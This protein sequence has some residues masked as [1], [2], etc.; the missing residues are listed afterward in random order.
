MVRL[1]R[2]LQK[3]NWFFQ[4]NASRI[5]FIIQKKLD[6]T[7]DS[8]GHWQNRGKKKGR[9]YWFWNFHKGFQMFSNVFFLIEK[10][11]SCSWFKVSIFSGFTWYIYTIQL[12]LNQI[13]INEKYIVYFE[14][15]L[16]QYFK[17]K[18]LYFNWLKKNPVSIQNL[19]SSLAKIKTTS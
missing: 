10:L 5:D 4:Q 11:D 16:I 3:K 15:F 14:R 18:D 2:M 13:S 17:C 8:Y 1:D 19:D 6:F 9:E 7:V 12:V